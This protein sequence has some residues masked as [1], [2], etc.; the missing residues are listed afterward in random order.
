MVLN[1]DCYDDQLMFIVLYA[2]LTDG[3]DNQVGQ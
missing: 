1:K 2:R 3:D